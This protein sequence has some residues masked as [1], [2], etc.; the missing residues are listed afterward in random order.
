M[1]QAVPP[2]AAAAV[3]TLRA[4]ARVRRTNHRGHN[5]ASSV[6]VRCTMAH[7]LLRDPQADGWESSEFPV[8]CEDCLGPNPYVRMQK[9]RGD[10]SSAQHVASLRLQ[11][12]APR[13]EACGSERSVLQA[14]T[15]PTL[16]RA[17]SRGCAGGVWHGVPHLRSPI[18]R[19]SLA[20]RARRAVRPRRACSSRLRCPE[21]PLA[22][23]RSFKKTVICREVAL[24]KNVCQVRAPRRAA[25][26]QAR[27]R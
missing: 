6:R 3:G 23:R 20:A 11:R 19:L 16:T 10:W 9:A 27:G 13:R 1:C 14:T 26:A 5:A 4:R 21:R 22:A 12:N 25:R 24:A 8:V 7:R 17:A 15:P 2:A 18:H